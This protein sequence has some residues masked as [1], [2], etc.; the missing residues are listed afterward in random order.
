M[1][2]RCQG[3]VRAEDSAQAGHEPDAGL[4]GD[5]DVSVTSEVNARR[6]LVTW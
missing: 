6:Q 5:R 1:E 2:V 4:G 3:P